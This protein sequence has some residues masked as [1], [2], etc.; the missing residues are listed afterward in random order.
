VR[1]TLRATRVEE[2]SRAKRAAPRTCRPT[3]TGR[4]KSSARGENG[5]PHRL[6]T[7]NETL[8]SP[9][10]GCRESGLRCR[11]AAPGLGERAS[12][13]RR[14]H[15]HHHHR[16]DRGLRSP[17]GSAQPCP[18]RRGRALRPRR[19]RHPGIRRIQIRGVDRFRGRRSLPLNSEPHG[20]RRAHGHH[21]PWPKRADFLR[22][23]SCSNSIPSPRTIHS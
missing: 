3:G 5:S 15:R 17:A 19:I 20:A 7:S 1:L 18:F 11:G 4:R 23:A 12:T 14:R 16:G 6:P 2:S 10:D 22:T 8:P 9:Y 21:L 13:A